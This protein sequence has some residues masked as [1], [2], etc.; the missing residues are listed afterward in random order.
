VIFSW[1]AMN[2]RWQL[3]DES[4]RANTGK[5][6]RRS[7]NEGCKVLPQAAC[8]RRKRKYPEVYRNLRVQVVTR[9]GR[10]VHLGPASPAAFDGSH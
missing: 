1:E 2:K 8:V 4:P 6:G 9:R 10:R 7:S 5:E 3:R